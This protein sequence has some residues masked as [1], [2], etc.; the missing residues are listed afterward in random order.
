MLLPIVK[1]RRF[2]QNVCKLLIYNQPS[3]ST[4]H[5]PLYLKLKIFFYI[6]EKRKIFSVLNV[7]STF[8]N[9]PVIRLT[10]KIIK[11]DTLMVIHTVQR[12]ILYYIIY[13]KAIIV[14]YLQHN[15]NTLNLNIK[16]ISYFW[17]MFCTQR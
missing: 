12:L 4:I 15:R 7:L 14:L 5:N 17:S 1:G 9:F 16:I 13:C 2:D 6:V 11:I 10:A 8:L 3:V